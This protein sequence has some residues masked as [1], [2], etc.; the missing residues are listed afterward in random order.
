MKL[1]KSTVL[2]TGFTYLEGPRWRDG[3]LWF[4]DMFGKRVYCMDPSG[5]MRSVV[6]VPDRPSGLGFD[7]DGNLL[8]VSMQDHTLYRVENGS[9]TKRAC[10]GDFCLGEI[11]DMVVDKMG[12]AYIGCFGFDLFSDEDYRDANLILVHPD[13]QVQ[14]VA[15]DL[16]FPNGSVLMN[17]DRLLVI[18]ES[19]GNCLTAF[20]VCHDGRLH[21]RR[22]F[23]D[24]GDYDPDGICLDQGSGVWVSAFERGEFIRVLEGGEI[25]HKIV[26]KDRFAVACQLGGDDGRT[27]F[28]LTCTRP[29]ESVCSGTSQAQIETA[30]VEIPSAG[31]P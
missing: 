20:D 7:P 3:K 9:L 14:V 17:D 19:Y 5:N 23:A 16:A 15:E 18:A 28:C 26:V 8:V 31:S 6:D 2:A 29:W 12:R 27:L 22:M 30:R 10:L 25:T 24:L 13:G 4:S 1:L 21:N 11:N